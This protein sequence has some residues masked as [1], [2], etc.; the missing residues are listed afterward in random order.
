METIYNFF[1]HPFFIIFGGITATLVILGF[2]INILFWILGIA[3]LLKRLGYGRWFRKIV[4]VA[5]NDHYHSLKRDLVDS[6]IFRE[7]N[8]SHISS[9]TL[10]KVKDHNLL[11]I[12][13]Q[14]FNE[15]TIKSILA[16][17]K[18]NAGMIFYYPGFSPRDG[19][20]IPNDLR[21]QISNTENTTIVNFRGRLLNDI[22]TTLITT[23]YGKK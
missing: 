13:Y 17:K 6:G 1:N 9:Q 4:I 16:Y 7:K 8:I 22:I 11:L 10:S 12:H 19:K 20:E 3:P 14:S 21:D 2:F 5:D 18:S 23:S 15:A